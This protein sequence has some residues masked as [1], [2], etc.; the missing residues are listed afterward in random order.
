MGPWALAP[1]LVTLLRLP[2]PI[3]MCE[4][5]YSSAKRLQNLSY[6]YRLGIE[7]IRRQPAR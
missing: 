7:P 3:L 1:P 4:H 2:A 6:A 5:E